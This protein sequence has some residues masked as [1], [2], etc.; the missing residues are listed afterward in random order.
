MTVAIPDE[1]RDEALQVEQSD[2]TALKYDTWALLS[3]GAPEAEIE[4]RIVSQGWTKWFAGWYLDQLRAE[5]LELDVFVPAATFYE[6]ELTSYHD[7]QS[8]HTHKVRKAR[9]RII[10]YTVSE[11]LLLFAGPLFLLLG[12]SA[13]EIVAVLMVV[14]VARLFLGVL[15]MVEADR[16][17]QA[18]CQPRW[19]C[20]F[21]IWCLLAPDKATCIPPTLP[22]S[23]LT[24]KPLESAHASL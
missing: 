4:A 17:L 1:L 8:E 11:L 7:W 13:A 12:G 19:F 21:T 14:W 16:L 15:A 6:R 2:L 23:S 5:G 22:Q 3:Q 18:Q 24:G 10:S 20:V 9:N